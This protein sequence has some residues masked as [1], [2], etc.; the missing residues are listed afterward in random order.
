MDISGTHSQCEP[1]SRIRCQGHVF[2]GDRHRPRTTVRVGKKGGFYISY[3]IL[4]VSC[5]KL[6]RAPLTT[7]LL[8]TLDACTITQTLIG[9][10]SVPSSV[11]CTVYGRYSPGM[12]QP[13]LN[14]DAVSNV[15]MSTSSLAL[16]SC[17]RVSAAKR[18]VPVHTICQPRETKLPCGVTA[19]I[20]PKHNVKATGRLPFLL[21]PYITSERAGY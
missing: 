15:R 3:H 5:E 18:R 20:A 12:I 9:L 19:S 1:S 14:L 16:K 2:G 8:C 4:L 21:D 7:I 10:C 13:T 6:K 11:T 17:H